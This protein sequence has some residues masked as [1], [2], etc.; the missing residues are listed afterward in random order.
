MKN[1]FYL[2]LILPFFLSGSVHSE[3]L[4]SRGIVSVSDFQYEKNRYFFIALSYRDHFESGH[5]NDLLSFTLD[6]WNQVLE[7][8]VWVSDADAVPAIAAVEPERY[9][10]ISYDDLNIRKNKESV[11]YK[12]R[13]RQLAPDQYGFD[14]DRGFFWLTE[15]AADDAVIA[16]TC[17]LKDKSEIGSHG[18]QE[19]PE[20]PVFQLIKPKNQV[21]TDDYEKT[22]PLMMK[23]VYD[24]GRNLDEIKNLNLA[25]LPADGSHGH[26]NNAISLS[27]NNPYL[28]LTGLDRL[29]EYRYQIY[30]GDGVVDFNSFNLN[31][32]TGILIF[33]SLHPF[34]P[35]PDSRFQLDDHP[36]ADIYNTTS[37]K[38]LKKESKYIISVIEI[39][40]TA[41]T[42]ESKTT[43]DGR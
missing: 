39:P 28:N 38:D 1:L 5:S 9:R 14:G 25:I 17:F 7:L 37:L 26:E 10:G 33:P 31:V 21:P 41:S 34:D 40:K 35:L 18:K 19:K 27:S 32:K 4:N 15:A 22:W 20:T 42:T 30:K 36:T 2:A 24:L 29:D 16:V 13:F 3:N 12:G 23:N 6:A 8:N 43:K 11:L